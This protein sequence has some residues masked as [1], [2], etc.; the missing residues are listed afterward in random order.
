MTIQNLFCL[1]LLFAITYSVDVKPRYLRSRTGSNTVD[2][3]L[4][5]DEK[6]KVRALSSLPYITEQ[7]EM[8]GLYPLLP[9]TNDNAESLTS[10]QNIGEP[11]LPMINADAESLTLARKPQLP[12]YYDDAEALTSDQLSYLDIQV[13]KEETEAVSDVPTA[14]PTDAP[15][16]GPTAVPTMN[17]TDAPTADPT[18]EPTIFTDNFTSEQLLYLDEQVG[19]KETEARSNISSTLN[20]HYIVTCDTFHLHLKSICPAVDPGVIHV[21][22]DVDTNGYVSAV[23]IVCYDSSP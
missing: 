8:E 4:N 10:E 13:A 23:R 11:L 21:Q 16:A 12:M 19:K 17:P 5:D 15:T 9:A 6:L 2:S 3:P 20:I 22:L 1:S 7:L 18:A 14:A